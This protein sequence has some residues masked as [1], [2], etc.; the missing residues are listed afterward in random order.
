MSGQSHAR[1]RLGAYRLSI[2]LTSTPALARALP[3][4]RP[5]GPAPMTS[6]STFVSFGI[7]VVFVYSPCVAKLKLM[8]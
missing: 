3:A 4:I 7:F 6:T 5:A 8:I 2:T 1:G